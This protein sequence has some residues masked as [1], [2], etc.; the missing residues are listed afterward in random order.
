MILDDSLLPL[1]INID[2]QY[3]MRPKVKNPVFSNKKAKKYP[4]PKGKTPYCLAKRAEY[5]ERD[6]EKAE[7]LYRQAVEEGERLES[8]IKDLATVI[9]QLGRTQEAIDFL[10]LHR[11]TYQGDL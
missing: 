3:E 9:H 4:I 10:I 2:E 11:P 6:L 8:S 7:K 1:K 5:M